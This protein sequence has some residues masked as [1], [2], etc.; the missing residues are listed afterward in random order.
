MDRVVD[1]GRGSTIMPDFWVRTKNVDRMQLLIEGL[2]FGF[3]SRLG[4]SGS[5]RKFYPLFRAKGRCFLLG[6]VT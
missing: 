3:V 4:G 1:L 6:I 5:S 2:L